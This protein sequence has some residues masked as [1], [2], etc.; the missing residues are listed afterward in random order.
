MTYGAGIS[1][2]ELLTDIINT[3]KELA[4]YE[5]LVEAHIV[6]AE[7]PEQEN[8]LLHQAKAHGYSA[9][10]AGCRKFL[11]RLMKLKRERGL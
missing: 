7:L 1:D 6:L 11:E 2:A 9:S 10:A 4:A 5:K 3:E 8:R